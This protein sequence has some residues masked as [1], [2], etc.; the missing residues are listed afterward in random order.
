MSHAPRFLIAKYVPDL[1]R[2]EP[3]NIGV[4]VW[5]DG[6][7]SA[8]FAGEKRNGHTSIIPPGHLHVQSKNAYR[9]W[10]NYWRAVIDKS[11]LVRPDGKA[12]ERDDPEF[13]RLM[14]TKS[15]Q[16]YYLFD[17]GEFA[18]RIELTELDDVAN[19]LF[20]ELV[21]TEADASPTKQE[22]ADSTRELSRSCKI[23]VMDS[24]LKDRRDFFDGFDFPVHVDGATLPFHFD[25]AIH[26]PMPMAVMSKVFLWKPEDVYKTAYEFKAMKSEFHIPR[27]KCAALILPTVS[28]LSN[29]DAQ[30]MRKMMDHVGIVI[31][32]RDIKDATRR[33]YSLAP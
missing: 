25:F 2:M 30:E 5:S 21:E 19:E 6:N 1:R 11:A 23:A 10:I 32:M 8:R 27:E 4:I 28:D 26:G 3:R 33:F 29:K 14:A 9:Q 7:I 16:Q 17:G 22:R 15:K 18:E 20:R 12:V 31:D 24:G 13:V